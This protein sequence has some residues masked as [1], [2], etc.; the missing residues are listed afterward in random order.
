MAAPGRPV[1]IVHC[2]QE[3]CLAAIRIGLARRL[4]RRLCTVSRLLEVSASTLS[5]EARF[6]GVALL[7]TPALS[8]SV[9]TEAKAGAFRRS[10]DRD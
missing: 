6:S 7:A 10:W 8:A 4:R 1:L 2:A 5:P 9:R 3:N